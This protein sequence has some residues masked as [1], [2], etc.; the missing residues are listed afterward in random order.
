MPCELSA[1]RASVHPSSTPTSAHVA[2]LQT[3]A[4]SSVPFLTVTFMRSGSFGIRV[5]GDYTS[6]F[7]HAAFFAEDSTTALMKAMPRTPSSIFG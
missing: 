6:N 3:A 7:V 1:R 4:K 2:K 5:A